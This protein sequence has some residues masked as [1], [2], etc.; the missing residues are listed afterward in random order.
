MRETTET[1]TDDDVT[2]TVCKFADD[3]TLENGSVEMTMDG[4]KPELPLYVVQL[5]KHHLVGCRQFDSLIL[6]LR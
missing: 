4:K 6:F 2:I 1:T 5:I 3:F